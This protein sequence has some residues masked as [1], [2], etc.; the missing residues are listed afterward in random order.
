MVHGRPA[1]K[2]LCRGLRT[3]SLLIP[4][5]NEQARLSSLLAAISGAARAEVATAG[6]ELVE[7]LVIDDGSRDETRRILTAAASSELTPVLDCVEHRGKGAAL[8]RGVLRARGD[9]VLLADADLSTPISELGKLAAAIDEGADLAIGSRAV[10]GAVVERGPLHRKLTGMTFSATVRVLTGLEVRDT[11][12]GFKLLGTATAR[13][14]FAEQ[15][16]PGF[17]FDVELLLRAQLVGL[18][19]IEVPVVYIHDSRSRV[20]VARAG[21]QMF[22]EVAL[23][24]RRLHPRS[25]SHTAVDR[26]TRG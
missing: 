15:L 25:N 6:F 13:S 18:R 5:F 7:T 3:L 16:C 9:Y 4:A 24:S 11:Q 1:A 2:N 20:K 8:R 23:L 12:N 17:G 21:L 10:A 22:R 26:P 14:L 19:I